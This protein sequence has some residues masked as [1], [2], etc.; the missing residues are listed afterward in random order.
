LART[1]LV[2]C[3]GGRHVVRLRAFAEIYRIDTIG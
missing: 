3:F 2:G 1:S